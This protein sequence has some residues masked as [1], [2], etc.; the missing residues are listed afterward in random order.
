MRMMHKKNPPAFHQWDI[1]KV[2]V[3]PTD[4]DEH[5]VVILTPD[6]LIA[7]RSR[8][9]VLFGTS[10]QPAERLALGQVLLD[11]ADGLERMTIIECAFFPVV[12][13]DQISA[14]VGTVSYERR[15]ILLST[16]AACLRGLP[17]P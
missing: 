12:R 4:R 1:V 10:K 13:L 7:R 5:Y 9:N 17:G 14:R 15:K 11:E 3:N 8:V 6:E 16:I 2:R